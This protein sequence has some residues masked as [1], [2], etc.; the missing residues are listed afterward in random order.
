MKDSRTR[1]LL[2]ALVVMV[3]ILVLSGIR[4]HDRPTWFLEV[5]PV[6]VVIPILWSTHRRFPLTTL[7][8]GLIFLHS[9]VLILGAIH[10]YARVPLGFAIADLLGLERNP[11]DRIGH[12]FQ[13]FVPAIVA[14]EVLIRG[15]HVRGPKMRVYII[16][17]IVLAISAAY[18]FIEWWVAL[19]AGQGA[20][21]FLGTQGDQWD[22][23]WDMFCAVIG[24]VTALVTLSGFHDRQ[25]RTLPGTKVATT[26]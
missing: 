23:Q 15:E 26:E 16:V 8:Y 2:V 7:L 14:R 5:L 3:G 12:F 21:Q 13:G 22:T 17:S 10:T 1:L 24:A 25:M 4:P 11:Y 19:L 9:L 6:L 18:E 20:D